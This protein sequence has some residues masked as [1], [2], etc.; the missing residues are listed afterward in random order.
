MLNSPLVSL[1]VLATAHELMQK[2]SPGALPA[3][4]EWRDHFAMLDAHWTAAVA[5]GGARAAG[6]GLG[7]ACAGLVVVYSRALRKMLDVVSATLPRNP[8]LATLQW[9][10]LVAHVGVLVA[11]EAHLLHGSTVYV[12]ATVAAASPGGLD[13]E[14]ARW[15]S[16]IH[17]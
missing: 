6:H 11:V 17:I 16:L 5:D 7:R 13:A 1:K 4:F 10:R 3:S 9:H 14:R 12:A 2:G 15:L 8:P